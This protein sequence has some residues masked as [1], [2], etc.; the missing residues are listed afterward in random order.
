MRLDLVTL[1][2]VSVYVIAL[3]GA[4][5]V[6]SWWQNREVRS[7][8]WW[9]GSLMLVSVSGVLLVKRGIWP[10]WTTIGAANSLL[11]IGYG[12]FWAGFRSFTR[13][14]IIPVAVIGGALVWLAACGIPNFYHSFGDRVLLASVIA[15]AYCLACA[16]ELWLGRGEVLLSRYPLLVLLVL[17]AAFLMSRFP[18]LNV[19]GETSEA[20]VFTT[21]WVSTHVFES[22]LFTIANAFLLLAMVKERVEREQRAIASSD[23]LTGI[24]NRRAF[25][26]TARER[27]DAERRVGRPVALLLFDLDHFKDVN[28]RFGHAVGDDVLRAFCNCAQRSATSDSIFARLGGEEFVLLL[29]RNRRRALRLANR[30]RDDFAQTR[31]SASGVT[32]GVT[33][34]AGVATSDDAGHILE[35]LLAAADLMLYQAKRAGRNRVESHMLDQEIGQGNSQESAQEIAHAA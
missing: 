20:T 17:H 7:L 13:R 32:F 5:L 10:D 22:L 33:V 27:L 9:G 12:L 31:F 11:F 19:W 14:R 1:C 2:V 29:P 15:A 24:L 3:V 28:D 34:S 8:A 4:L 26:A 6:F 16:G 25:L 35:A 18:T 30:L 23:A 21:P